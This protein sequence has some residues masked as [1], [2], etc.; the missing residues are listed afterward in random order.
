MVWRRSISRPA[1]SSSAKAPEDN[2]DAEIARIDPA[3]IVASD[4][5]A[6]LPG[7]KRLC[8]ET[9]RPLTPLGR[10]SGDGLSAAR[11]ILDYFGLATLDGLGAFSRAEIAAAAAALF[12]IER[13]QFSARPALN[14]PSR[15][16]LEAHMSI[17]AATRANLELTRT[18]AGAREG[19][20]IGAIDRT[21]TAPGGRLLAERLAAPLTDIAAISRRR[22][23]IAFFLDEPDL[24]QTY[25]ACLKPFRI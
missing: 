1:N 6:D 2:L 9:K 15:V 14:L 11:R 10:Q 17:D 3:E 8:A 20:L 18:L 12:Y 7:L 13:T 24:R 4:A 19:S 25:A 23:S 22:G 5:L 16:A 21:V